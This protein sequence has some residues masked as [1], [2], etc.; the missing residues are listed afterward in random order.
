MTKAPFRTP[1]MRRVKLCAGT[2]HHMDQLT[3][4]QVALPCGFY[5]QPMKDYCGLHDPEMRMQ[6]KSRPHSETKET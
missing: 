1:N 5:A 6:L 2:I 3:G 4:K